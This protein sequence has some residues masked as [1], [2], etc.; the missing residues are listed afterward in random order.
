MKNQLAR[1]L[2]GVDTADQEPQQVCALMKARKPRFGIVAAP[3]IQEDALQSKHA[4]NSCE[5]LSRF[6]KRVLR[7]SPW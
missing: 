5:T 1:A 7:K 2:R 6:M 3:S 4:S